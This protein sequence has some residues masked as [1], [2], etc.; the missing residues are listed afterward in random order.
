M[1]SPIA[2][3]SFVA[4]FRVV[5]LIGEGAMGSVYLAEDASRGGRVALKVLVRDLADDERFR[6]RFLRESKLAVSLDHP[7]VVSIVD[8]GEEGGVLYLAMELVEGA[9]LRALLRQESRLDPERAIGLLAQVADA[10]DAAHAAG[11]VHRD[12]KPANILVRDEPEGEHAYVCDFGLARHLSS[13]SSLTTDRGVVGTIDYIP[14]EQIEGGEIDGRADVYSLGC[15][16]FE[17]L[18]GVRPF[19]RESELSVVFAHL[20]EQPPRLSEYRPD[21][22]DAFDDVFA[23]AL[24]KSPG[25]RYATCRELVESARAALSG[26]TPGRRGRPL[27]RML[28]GALAV[29]VAAGVATAGILVMRGGSASASPA[30]TQTSIAG[31]PL[32]LHI[33]GYRKILGPPDLRVD[34]AKQVP[35]FPSTEYPTLIFL[36]PKVAVFFPD[37]WGSR[38]KIIVTW[39]QDFKTAAGVGPCSTIEKLKATYGDEVR[40]DHWGTITKKNGTT[41]YYM[42]D[43]GKNLLF[44]VSGE[45][46]RPHHPIPGKYV[47]A[48][49]LFDGSVPDA[50]VPRGPRNFAGFVTGNETPECGA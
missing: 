31:A 30:I 1:S 27:R 6:K 2:T 7:N 3:G 21:L 47:H 13:A 44:P 10:L 9:D 43:V 26:E 11:L 17:C 45:L 34:Q 4:G 8:A 49:G 41:D 20:N 32:G 28:V 50:D 16:L 19:D 48:V 36:R 15:V 24:A 42:Y 22:S 35:G 40:P 33:A 23:T 46:S 29:L 39:N 25:D 18:A 38:A 12:V 14:P 37:G 5:S